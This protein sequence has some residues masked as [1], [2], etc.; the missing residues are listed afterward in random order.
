MKIKSNCIGY[1]APPF[2]VHLCMRQAS[3]LDVQ[4]HRIKLKAAR[5]VD[6]PCVSVTV[7]YMHVVLNGEDYSL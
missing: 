6:L 1:C 4:N 5:T 2:H 7:F 3:G